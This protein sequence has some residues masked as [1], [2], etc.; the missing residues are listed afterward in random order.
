MTREEKGFQETVCF[1]QI[2]VL[3]FTV[4]S[5]TIFLLNCC[6]WS[7]P[8]LHHIS[9]QSQAKFRPADGATCLHLLKLSSIAKI[10][11]RNH[12]AF[13]ILQFINTPLMFWDKLA[14]HH[15]SSHRPNFV[16]PPLPLAFVLK[17]VV[18]QKMIQNNQV[19]ST[20]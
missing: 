1:L 17:K 12:H 19:F 14:I 4:H 15:N 10:V 11:V 2:H 3:H 18:T 5:L 20:F 13:S 8:M 16:L 9:S 7:Q 6:F